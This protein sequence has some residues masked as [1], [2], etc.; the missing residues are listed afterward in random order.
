MNGSRVYWT[1]MAI[2]SLQVMYDFVSIKWDQQIMDVLLDAVDETIGRIQQHPGIAQ[3]IEGTPFRRYVLHKYVSL[4]YMLT[5]EQVKI[6][7]VWDNRMDDRD[8]IQ[9]LTGAA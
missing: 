3:L 9:R 5:D 6:L 1:P 8:L 4:Y 7:L 2:E